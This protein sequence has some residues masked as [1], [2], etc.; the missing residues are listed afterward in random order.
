MHSIRDARTTFQANTHTHSRSYLNMSFRNLPV[1]PALPPLP[2][3]TL[4][5]A[6]AVRRTLRLGGSHA[7]VCRYVVAY[8]H[9]HVCMYVCLHVCM[10]VCACM[11]ACMHAC[12]HKQSQN[13]RLSLSIHILVELNRVKHGI[14]DTL[15]RICCT[16]TT[17]CMYVCIHYLYIYTYYNILFAYTH[18]HTSTHT[19]THT[20]TYICLPH[21]TARP[22]LSMAGHWAH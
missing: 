7:R 15:K 14:Y 20:N 9:M 4:I 19:H 13:V 12:T 16:C 2:P 3:S 22:G 8:V 18:T 17:V 11:H 10:C 6:A 21:L 5:D 1:N